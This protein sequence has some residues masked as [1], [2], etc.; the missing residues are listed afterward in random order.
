MASLGTTIN[1]AEIEP[2]RGF[3]TIPGAE[4]IMQIIE[5]EVQPAGTGKGQVLKL[6]WDVVDGEYEKSR[7][8]ENVNFLHD[9]PKAQLIGQQHIKE[10]CDAV[11]FQGNLDDAD[12][13]MFIPCRVL[14]GIERGKPR[15]EGGVYDDK[16]TIKRVK[17][18]GAAPAPAGKAP[19]APATTTAA[20]P[21]AATTIAAK[22][23]AAG[24][25]GNRPWRGAAA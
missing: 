7:V 23:A 18:I 17:P 6:T 1:P 25:A 13:L 8:W 10:I 4:Y 22:P 5:N 16:N 14:V 21:A 2:G 3:G 19:V 9:N 11:G 20:K 12:V 15:P 24:P